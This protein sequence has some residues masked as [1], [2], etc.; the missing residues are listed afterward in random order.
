MNFFTSNVKS[1]AGRFRGP[2]A[3]R[4]NGLG[5]SVRLS[6]P[7][8][9]CDLVGREWRDGVSSSVNESR[10]EADDGSTTVKEKS[11]SEVHPGNGI[12]ARYLSQSVDEIDLLAASQAPAYEILRRRAEISSISTRFSSDISRRVAVQEELGTLL[13]DWEMRFNNILLSKFGA[14]VPTVKPEGQEVPPPPPPRYDPAKFDLEGFSPG[15][16]TVDSILRPLGVTQMQMKDRLDQ[17]LREQ[18]EAFRTHTTGAK[19]AFYALGNRDRGLNMAAQAFGIIEDARREISHFKVKTDF[20]S[21]MRLAESQKLGDAGAEAMEDALNLLTYCMI[22]LPATSRPWSDSRWQDADLVPGRGDPR[23]I[24]A[25]G[26]RPSADINLDENRNLGQNIM[27]PRFVDL[28]NNLLVI[29]G[30]EDASIALFVESLLFRLLFAIE[31]GKLTFSIFDPTGLGQSVSRLLEL[32][33]FNPELIGGKAWSSSQ[34]LTKL[35][36]E[37]TAHIELVIQKYLRSTYETIEE[38]NEAAGE[39]A[40]PYKTLVIFGFPTG[41]TE[42]TFVELKQ[43]VDNGPRCGVRVILVWNSSLPDQYGVNAKSILNWKNIERI[44]PRKPFIYEENGYEMLS[45]LTWEQSDQIDPLVLARLT[46]QVGRQSIVEDGAAVMLPKIFGLFTESVSKGI[47]QEFPVELSD[48]NFDDSTTWWRASTKTGVF[49]PIGQKGAREVAVLTFDSRDHAGALLVGRQGSGKTTLLHTFIAGVT[50]IY[51]PAE[52][53]LYLIDFKEGV[54]FKMYAEEALPHAKCVAIESD[55]EFGLSVLES[56]VGELTRRGELFR[57]TGGKFAGL[58][59]LRDATG[60]LLPRVILIF[61]E[62]HVLFARNDKI[63][64]A[65]SDMLETLIRQGRGFGIHVLLGSQSLS[66]I[67]ALG[68][69][70]PQLLPVRILLPALEADC[71][72]VLGDANDAGK[73]LTTHGEGILNGASGAV[74]ANE[75]FKGAVIYE[76]DRLVRLQQLR[77][78][79]D[80]K[81]WT[82]RPLIFEGNRAV[83][84]E[85]VLPSEF[86]RMPLGH[87]LHVRVGEPMTVNG[88]AEIILRRESGSNV[89]VVAREGIIASTTNHESIPHGLLIAML[90]S[91]AR[92]SVQVE[93]VDFTSVDDGLEVLVAPSTKSRQVR[94]SRRRQFPGVVEKLVTE[95]RKRI[96]EDDIA[97]P[98]IVLALFGVQRA[99]DLDAIGDALYADNDLSAMVEE[100]LRDGPETGIHVWAWCDSITSARR[101]FSNAGLRE[102]AWRIAGRLSSDD[103]QSM[104]SNDVASGLRD[105]QI[106]IVNDDLGV[107]RRCCAYRVPSMSWLTAVFDQT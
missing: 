75:R 4:L 90:A 71:Q 10:F 44:M 14:R 15:M 102:F 58:E 16:Y 53:E 66:G 40:E 26:L 86:P 52:I 27:W 41:F 33:E 9:S 25:G 96:A 69:H 79:S 57:S 3:K 59:T 7:P 99:R 64:M 42:H 63:G 17:L 6:P 62:F 106:V 55:R 5:Y 37:L 76:G 65:A 68:V 56:L 82:Q 20:L 81:G 74:E 93:L 43:I 29:H 18:D 95:V 70:V 101:R 49:A 13:A 80:E 31:P 103:S 1:T 104:L 47:R 67:D 84:M 92:M 28:T 50:S 85:R 22:N 24:Y 61:D 2:I 105:Q 23:I 36:S 100:I 38:F 48:F 87:E 34:D 94:L 72:K 19:I 45:T 91:L 88:T 78:L 39:I 8:L 30:A 35:L 21:S 11:L 51:S 32:S 46:N 97:A 83:P 107:V 54:E 89:L 77:R 12:V 98:P 60:E 73:Y